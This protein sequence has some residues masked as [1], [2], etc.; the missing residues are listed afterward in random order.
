M[1]YV[2]QISFPPANGASQGYYFVP[3]SHKSAVFEEKTGLQKQL[4]QPNVQTFVSMVFGSGK[5]K[6]KFLAHSVQPV[7]R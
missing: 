1:Q 2:R 3:K 7:L 5:M 4:W 6:D